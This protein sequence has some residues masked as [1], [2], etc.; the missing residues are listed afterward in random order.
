MLRRALTTSAVALI[1][2]VCALTTQFLTSPVQAQDVPESRA[3]AASMVSTYEAV[4]A[5][6]HDRQGDEILAPTR[7]ALRQMEPE[8]VLIALMEGVEDIPGTVLAEGID[9]TW[10]TFPQ[11]M[12]AIDS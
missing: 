11:Y 3:T 1:V 5:E 9:F 7:A 6:C 10:E 8:Q 4:C 2:L 12:D